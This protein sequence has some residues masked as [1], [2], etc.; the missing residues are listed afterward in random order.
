MPFLAHATTPHPVLAEQVAQETSPLVKSKSLQVVL[1]DRMEAADSIRDHHQKQQKQVERA[2]KEP[3]TG[4]LNYN[5]RQETQEAVNRSVDR[6][7]DE[8]KQSAAAMRESLRQVQM[9]DLTQQLFRQRRHERIHDTTL[10]AAFVDGPPAEVVTSSQWH[11]IATI[12]QESAKEAAAKLALREK[13]D[14]SSWSDSNPLAAFLGWSSGSYS[15]RPPPSSPKPPS[16]STGRIL[17]EAAAGSSPAAS[18]KKAESANFR[19]PPR[20]P[21]SPPLR[22]H[23][24]VAR[25]TTAGMLSPS[26]GSPKKKTSPSPPPTTVL[27]LGSAASTDDNAGG[28]PGGLRTS[29]YLER[30][31]TRRNSFTSSPSGVTG[32]AIGTSF[33]NAFKYVPGLEQLKSMQPAVP[34]EAESHRSVE[35]PSYRHSAHHIVQGDVR[36]SPDIA[37]PI[38]PSRRSTAGSP[39][40]SR[41]STP[42]A[43]RPPIQQTALGAFEA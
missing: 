30:R 18:S 8:R 39:H 5:A 42:V 7:R 22:A 10:Q 34:P 36:I 41:S 21:R 14:G 11:G 33:R 16:A 20:P 23:G 28:S 17:S 3:S 27:S 15:H 1:D 9:R 37:I 29:G 4:K 43:V 12:H 6:V 35:S 32:A 38:V 24:P 25:T 19:S 2:L 26:K 40:R 31:R 13:R